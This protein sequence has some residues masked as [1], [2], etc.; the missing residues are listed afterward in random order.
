[1]GTHRVGELAE[2]VNKLFEHVIELSRDLFHPNNTG[3]IDLLIFHPEYS[4]DYLSK[5]SVKFLVIRTNPVMLFCTLGIEKKNIDCIDLIYRLTSAIST[6]YPISLHSKS[7][8]F[9]IYSE[10]LYQVDSFISSWQYFQSWD[11]NRDSRL[12]RIDSFR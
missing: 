9:L 10:K 11:K 3:L 1:M 12:R 6:L 2:G 4:N 8:V 5:S 7:S